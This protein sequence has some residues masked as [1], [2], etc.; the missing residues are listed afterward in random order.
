MEKEITFASR[1]QFLSLHPAVSIQF[2]AQ[3]HIVSIGV[4]LLCGQPDRWFVT[5]QVNLWRETC[6]HLLVLYFSLFKGRSSSR[7]RP[8]NA[9]VWRFSPQNSQTPPMSAWGTFLCEIAHLASV[10]DSRIFMEEHFWNKCQLQSFQ[11][12]LQSTQILQTH[13]VMLFRNMFWFSDSCFYACCW[14]PATVPHPP[15]I[16]DS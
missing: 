5:R 7:R 9:N 15:L 11:P 16:P 2:F 1:Q 4:R 8:C 13:F 10:Q 12:Q 6:S 3:R 14:F